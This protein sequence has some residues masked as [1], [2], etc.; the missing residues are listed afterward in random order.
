MPLWSVWLIASS[1]MFIL[2]IFTVGFLL[3]FPAIGAFLAFIFAVF[4]ATS[5]L[6]VI[7]FV[8]TSLLMIA[9]IRPIVTKFFKSKD[10]AMNSKSVIG[11]NG[12]V[13]KTINNLDGRGQIKV[14]GEI[15]TAVSESD[16]EIAEGTTVLVQKVEGV[17]LVVK[18]V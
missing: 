7:V 8:V 3:F 14:A 11:K 13:I 15:W 2:E 4:G 9:F 17:K 1:I 16:D 5:E 18:K 10:V 6:Q 12:I